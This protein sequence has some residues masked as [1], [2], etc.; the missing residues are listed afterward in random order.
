MNA[1][2]RISSAL[3]PGILLST[4]LAPAVRGDVVTRWSTRAAE[5]VA[6]A[7]LPAP[8]AYRAMA[9]VQTAVLGAV[10]AGGISGAALDAAVAAA[11]RDALAE[12]VPAQRA[13]IEGEYEQALASIPD[14]PAKTEG[15]RAGTAAAA[16]VLESRR[17]DGADAPQADRPETAPGRYVATALPVLPQWPG[18]KPWILARA[19]QFRPGPPPALT[20]ETW[21]RD[22]AEIRA[23]GG[24]IGSRRTEEQTRVARF[25]EATAPSIYLEVVGSVAAMPGRDPARNA[26]LYA[27]ATQ[28]MDDALIAAF[29]AKYHYRFWRPVTAI[30]NGDQDGNDATDRD[31]AWVPFVE[32]PMHPEYPAAHC[33]LAG[34]VAAVLG[35]EIGA[36]PAP[37]LRSVSP[38]APGEVRTWASLDA[39]VQEV[40]D[41]RIF[42]GVHFRRSTEVGTDLGRKVGALASSR[43]FAKAQ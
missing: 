41:A 1:I 31:A 4:L 17:H 10:E 22:Y 33:S 15:L 11:N 25:W 27:A 36:G 28:A 43:H 32:T 34:A 7:K 26:R 19:D 3:V 39:F 23:V 40:A 6:A 13:A 38:T 20:S 21:A 8:Q 35:A 30:R 2:A 37:V 14:G 18:R 5:I 12:L 9:V 16:A 42:D 24:R 29:D